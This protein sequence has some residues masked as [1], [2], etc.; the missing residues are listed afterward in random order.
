[1]TAGSFHESVRFARARCMAA[2][3]YVSMKP[4][5]TSD[6]GQPTPSPLRIGRVTPEVFL[7]SQRSWPNA[8]QVV[9]TFRLWLVKNE[10]LYQKPGFTFPV[11]A[12]PQTLPLTVR[13]SSAPG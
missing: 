6:S 4:S 3:P 10:E 9:G 8:A 12:P 2:P 13:G 5:V 1:M 7:M 11:Y